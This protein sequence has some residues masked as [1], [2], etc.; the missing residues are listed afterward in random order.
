MK[1]L[2]ALGTLFLCCFTMAGCQPS[3]DGKQ[4]GQVVANL[5]L[6]GKITFT[7]TRNGG[8]KQVFIMNADGSNQNPSDNSR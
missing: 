3:K 5:P 7:S 8:K 4:D 1:Q 2:M 6:Q